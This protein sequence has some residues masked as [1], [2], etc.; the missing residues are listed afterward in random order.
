MKAGAW[1]A[2]PPRTPSAP[3]ILASAACD[4]S[5]AWMELLGEDHLK[6]YR[7]KQALEGS[8]TRLLTSGTDGEQHRA[9]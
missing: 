1:P 7:I 8:M 6:Y 3:V 4:V 5:Q 2:A 9:G